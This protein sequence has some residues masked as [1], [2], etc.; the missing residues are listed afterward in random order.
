MLG[1]GLGRQE[2]GICHALIFPARVHWIRA[3]ESPKVLGPPTDV[4]VLRTS[5]SHAGAHNHSTSSVICIFI[6]SPKSASP[7]TQTLHT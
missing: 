1:A 6:I 2:Q 5:D 3:M 7:I 4:L